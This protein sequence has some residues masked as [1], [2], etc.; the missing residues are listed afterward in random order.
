M[1]TEGKLF[2]PGPWLVDYESIGREWSD[3]VSVKDAEGGGH[4]A[5][6]TRGF[7]ADENGDDGPSLHNARLIAAAPELY[8][9]LENIVE[10]FER[11]MIRAGSDPEF[12]AEAVK[13]ARAALAKATGDPAK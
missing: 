3:S 10:R 4:I 7:Q 6:L 9:E 8:S 12:A 2:T 5:H 1:T 11:C 13:S